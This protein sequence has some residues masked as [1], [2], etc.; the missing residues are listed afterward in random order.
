MPLLLSHLNPPPRD[1]ASPALVAPIRPRP[2]PLL[3]FHGH[4][5]EI[6]SIITV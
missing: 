2:I 4:E 5:S 1:K 6:I 3:E